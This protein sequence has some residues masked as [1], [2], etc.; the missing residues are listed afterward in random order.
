MHPTLLDCLRDNDGLSDDR[1]ERG[2]WYSGAD[3]PPTPAPEMPTHD[4][5]YYDEQ[6]PRFQF[7]Y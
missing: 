2:D 5:I 1:D 4:G 7:P 3:L 6:D